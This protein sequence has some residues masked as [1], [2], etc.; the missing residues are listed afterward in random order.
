MD[1]VLEENLVNHPLPQQRKA[2]EDFRN[3]GIGIMGMHDMFIKM[4]ITYGSNESIDLVTY[5]I[6]FI[7]KHAI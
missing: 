3:Q 7:F 5:L 4:G 2:V 6:N 1:D